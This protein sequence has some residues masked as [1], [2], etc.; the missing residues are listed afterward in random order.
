MINIVGDVNFTDANFDIGF[1]VG[2][3]IKKGQNPFCHLDRK[4]QDYW[5]GNFEGVV[6]DKSCYTG[7]K[8]KR[9]LI[10]TTCLKN[11]NFINCYSVA[12]NH[13]MEHGVDAY[14]NMLSYFE[15]R[16]INY[17]GSVG[18]KS[19]VIDIDDKTI[20]ITGISFRN[21]K[22]ATIPKY[23]YDFDFGDMQEEYNKI[24]HSDFKIL[25]L[26]WGCEFINYP[27]KEQKIMARMMID[28]GFDL[29]IGTHPHI[30]QGFEIYKGKSIFYSIGNFVFN[31]PW[32][33]L[34]YGAI[35]KVDTKDFSVTY[36]YIHIG[37]DYFPSIIKEEEVPKELRFSNLNRLIAE[38]DENIE[39]YIA[40]RNKLLKRYRKCNY[41]YL[42][43][44]LYK[45]SF[46]DMYLV[47]KD[48]IKRKL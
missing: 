21:D 15:S 37:N 6:A 45:A 10:P 4:C 35:I 40:S 14:Q 22:S 12:N 42:L 17:F 36:D 23:W 20:S 28:M 32:N 30:L 31:K 39:D 44:N 7:L 46:Y 8:E 26:H 11:V 38:K 25:Y 16:G 3:S 18:K 2:S 9:F 43:K 29:I 33:W 34:K 19:H 27:Y 13:V 24:R 1:G 48:F 47:L 5:I 41:C